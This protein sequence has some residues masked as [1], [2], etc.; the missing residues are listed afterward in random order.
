MLER[1][2]VQQLRDFLIIDLIIMHRT[3]WFM[4]NHPTTTNLLQCDTIIADYLN[5]NEPC[6]V[7]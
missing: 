1:I 2:V 7:L 5:V 3:T 6:E 4:P